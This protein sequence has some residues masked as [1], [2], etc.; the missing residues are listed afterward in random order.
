ML[1]RVTVPNEPMRDEA[2][3]NATEVGL[4]ISSRLRIDILAA[5][6]GTGH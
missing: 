5:L 1:L 2:P 4:N 6:P 3:T